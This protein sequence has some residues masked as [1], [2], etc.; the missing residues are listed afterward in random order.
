[1]VE[2]E[3]KRQSA[4]LTFSNLSLKQFFREAQKVNV[5]QKSG[6]S[7]LRS[8]LF[9]NISKPSLILLQNSSKKKLYIK[10]KFHDDA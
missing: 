8:G 2:L 1:M 7:Y 10:F 9:G 4:R 5:N 3:N 6:L